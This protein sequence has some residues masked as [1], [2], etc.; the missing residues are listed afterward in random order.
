M[1]TRPPGP[2]GRARAAFTL[3]ELLVVMAII[4]ILASLLLP[5]LNR[6]RDAARRTYCMSNLRQIGTTLRLYIDDNNGRLPAVI[7]NPNN[8]TEATGLLG[9]DWFLY[10]YMVS[11]RDLGTNLQLYPKV[12]ACPADSYPR[13]AWCAPYPKRSYSAT[14]GLLPTPRYGEYTLFDYN[15][16][17]TWVINADKAYRETEFIRGMARTVFLQDLPFFSQCPLNLSSALHGPW[18]NSCRP[19]PEGDKI[20]QDPG[21]LATYA[22]GRDYHRPGANLLYCDGHVQY[23][24]K[25][26]RE[27]YVM[28]YYPTLMHDPWH[29]KPYNGVKDYDFDPGHTCAYSPYYSPNY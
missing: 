10:P 15:I 9:F 8:A 3:I 7:A 29:P 18:W 2:C 25:W 11:S 1:H 14:Y 28:A 26:P 13:E 5:S 27:P 21:Y 20:L 19:D 17:S 22:Y 6:A 24:P 23:W 12:F 16:L 4:A